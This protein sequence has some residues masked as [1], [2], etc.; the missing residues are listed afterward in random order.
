MQKNAMH[1]GSVVSLL[2]EVKWPQQGEHFA[3]RY[4]F[5]ILAD[6]CPARETFNPFTTRAAK[7][8]QLEMRQFS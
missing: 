2:F 8:G 4:G 1:H 7:S 6:F 3:S 5:S